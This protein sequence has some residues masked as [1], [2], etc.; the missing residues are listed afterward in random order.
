MF[1]AANTIDVPKEHSGRM[2]EN[3]RKNAPD[4]KQFEGFIG[5]EMWV[6]ESGKLLAVSKW[7]SRAHFEKY[8][9][10]EAFRAHHGGHNAEQTQQTHGQA[11]V[12]YYEGETLV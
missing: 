6:E 2:V 4:L 11:Q 9:H 1:I 12:S 3:F 10:S 8:I 7:E 5:F